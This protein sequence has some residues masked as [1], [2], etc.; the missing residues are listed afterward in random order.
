MLSEIKRMQN[1]MSINNFNFWKIICFFYKLS[2]T[3]PERI[4]DT[5]LGLRF[6]SWESLL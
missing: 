4:R 5:L 6:P 2:P 3:R 1:Q